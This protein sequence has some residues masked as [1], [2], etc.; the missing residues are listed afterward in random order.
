MIRQ[1][2]EELY[3]ILTRGGYLNMYLIIHDGALTLVDCAL[4]KS[5]ID[6]VA[7]ALASKGW[8]LADIR[9]V[10]ITHAH[11]DHIGGLANLQQRANPHTMAHRLDAPIIRGEQ[12]V[13]IADPRELSGLNRLLFPILSN[14]PLVTPARVDRELEDGQLLDEVLPQLRVIH[15]PGHS[16]GQVGFWHEG[17]RWLIG[18]DVMMRYL[19]RL[20][21]PLRIVS[22]DWEGVKS[23]IRKV[24]AMDVDTLCLGH[25]Q[26][27]VGN[28][29]AAIADF[30]AAIG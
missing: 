10:L 20:R 29:R 18:G 27:L 28:A 15:L 7:S 19:G 9:H 5:D 2:R 11:T 4:G 22:P 14:P 13:S 17:G 12:K 26:P 25:G 23:A 6:H 1:I 24:A 30:A 16:H 3:A 8:S 21:M